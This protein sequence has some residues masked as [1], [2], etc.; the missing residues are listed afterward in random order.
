LVVLPVGPATWDGTVVMSIVPIEI[1]ACHIDS[2]ASET[3]SI[4]RFHRTG[5]KVPT[6]MGRGFSSKEVEEM[7]L[8]PG[9]EARGT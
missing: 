6:K 2:S 7:M 3:Y 4:I 5:V 1:T 8:F 9:F